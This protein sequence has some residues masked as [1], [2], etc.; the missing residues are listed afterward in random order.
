MLVE[1]GAEAFKIVLDKE[2]AEELRDFDL[3]CDIPRQRNHQEDHYSQ[4]PDGA[5]EYFSITAH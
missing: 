3:H 5:P 4:P 1:I 2:D